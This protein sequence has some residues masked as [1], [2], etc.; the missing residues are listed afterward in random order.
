MFEASAGEA[1]SDR[2][3][4]VRGNASGSMPSRHA[5]KSELT[6]C[7]KMA[8]MANTTNVL[9]FTWADAALTQETLTSSRPSGAFANKSTKSIGS[10]HRTDDPMSSSHVRAHQ[11]IDA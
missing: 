1:A 6:P 11:C 9:L 7:G 5:R 10:I 8:K 4:A 3:G 2:G